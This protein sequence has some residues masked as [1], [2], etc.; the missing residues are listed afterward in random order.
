MLRLFADVPDFAARLRVAMPLYGMRW[1]M[2]LLNEFLPGIARRRHLASGVERYDGAEAQRL[3]LQKALCYRD[4]VT[5]I[6]AN[7]ALFADQNKHI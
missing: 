6:Y 3:Q 7:A 2:I 5:K 1:I 4:R